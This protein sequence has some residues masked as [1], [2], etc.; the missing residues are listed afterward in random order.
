MTPEQLPLDLPFRAAMG[1][2]DFFVS[3]ANRA[4]VAGIDAWSDWP[5]AKMLLIGPQGAGKT[6]LA[7]VWA[8]Q[9]GA[10][11][12]GPRALTEAALPDLAEAPA[13][14][15]EDADRIAGQLD[16]ETALFHLHNA[17]SQRGAPLLITAR[18]PPSRWEMGLPD[19]DSRMAQTGQL[20]LASPDDVLLS[21]VMV[22]LA[23]DRQLALTP[24][25]VS[26]AMARVERSF[27]AVQHLVAAL[28]ALALSEQK[29]PMT[30][31]IRMILAETGDAD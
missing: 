1:R 19:L 2:S 10:T 30:R 8:A 31:H 16:P 22:K 21:A 7:H 29:P 4:A 20:T 24:A 3:D 28:D 27:A 26:Y 11:V 6:H 23:Q 17:L 5:L 13:L 15:V 12:I 14:V 9:A 18:R 25:L